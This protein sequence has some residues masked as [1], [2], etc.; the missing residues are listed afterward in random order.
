MVHLAA[1][2]NLQGS[3]YGIDQVVGILSRGAY[4]RF[5]GLSGKVT[6][7]QQIGWWQKATGGAR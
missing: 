4:V 3:M 1:G 7:K 6:S 2:A 5:G